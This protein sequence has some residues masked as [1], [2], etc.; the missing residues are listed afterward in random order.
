MKSKISI[1]GTEYRIEIHKV[2]EDK[3]LKDGSLCGYCS[4]D[5]KLIV[6]ADVSENEYFGNMNEKEREY[7]GKKTTRHEVIHAFFNESGLCESSNKYDGAWTRNE[8]MVDW[9][10]IQ[11]PKI[12]EAFKELEIL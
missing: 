5:D 1:L 2:S 3:Y 4:D 6:I 12:F 7:F 10:A 8:E 11:S 9:F